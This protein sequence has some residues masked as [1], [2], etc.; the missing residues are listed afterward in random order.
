[1]IVGAV[2]INLG[3][4]TAKEKKAGS[5]CLTGVYF[6]LASNAWILLVEVLRL[7]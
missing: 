6:F 2:R 4:I 5:S 1:L 3:E 7:P